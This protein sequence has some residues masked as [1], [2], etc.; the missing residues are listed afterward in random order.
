MKC[1]HSVTLKVRGPDNI[2]LG[3]SEGNR[4]TFGSDMYIKE[5][6]DAKVEEYEGDYEVIPSTEAQTLETENKFLNQDVLIKEIPTYV[7]SNEYGKTFIIG[8]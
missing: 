8:D 2:K 4:I 7:T 1:I 3:F 5:S 6:H